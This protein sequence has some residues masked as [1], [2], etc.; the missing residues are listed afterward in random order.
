MAMRAFGED[1]R[2]R[3]LRQLDAGGMATVY[4]AADAL[5]GDAL[6]A[7]KVP[8]TSLIAEPAFAERFRQ[9]AAL[10]GR[11]ASPC[12]VRTVD[13][14]TSGLAPYVAMEYVGGGTLSERLDRR[15]PLPQTEALR[16]TREVAVALDAAAAAGVL[17]RDVKP[18]N[19][20][21]TKDGHA[22]L[23]DFGIAQ[24]EGF[25]GDGGQGTFLGT[26]QYVAPEVAQGWADA[27]ADIYSLGVV[28]YEMLGGRP[29]FSGDTREVLLAHAADPPPPL[30]ATLHPRVRAIVARCLRKDPVDR[31]PTARALA[32]ECTATLTALTGTRPTVAVRPS[33]ASQRPNPPWANPRPDGERAPRS[34]VAA[35]EMLASGRRAGRP[36]ARPAPPNAGSPF[37]GASLVVQWGNGSAAQHGVVALPAGAVLRIGRADDNALRLRDPYVSRH[38]AEIAPR[39]DGHVLRDLRSRHGTYVRGLPVGEARL[40]DG[41]IITVGR[42]RLTYHAPGLGVLP[43][44]AA[45]YQRSVSGF[46]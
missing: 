15:G 13:V 10:M 29:P 35:T 28:L 40:N 12:I 25:V 23:I 36:P 18:R 31:F 42:T 20:L 37:D 26:V 46:P 1:G 9:E 24:A 33:V 34:H 39:D 38:Q 21:L 16:I 6:V 44:A 5:N 4:L 45:R 3:V 19:I 43:P 22:K 32:A 14:R 7:L 11:L 17:H 41:D 27:R 8:H 30:S 2:F